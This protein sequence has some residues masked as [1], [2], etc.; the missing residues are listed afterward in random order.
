MDL[1]ELSGDI[2]SVER[3]H[4][5]IIGPRTRLQRIDPT[6]GRCLVNL[7]GYGLAM[8]EIRLRGPGG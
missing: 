7:W 4:G 1:P 8:F 5:F 3:S 2:D 6:D